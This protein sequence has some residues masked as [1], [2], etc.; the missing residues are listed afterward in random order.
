V[1]EAYHTVGADQEEW[2]NPRLTLVEKSSFLQVVEAFH[3][4][5]EELILEEVAFYIHH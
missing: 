2:D 3:T 5:W 1:E 4:H